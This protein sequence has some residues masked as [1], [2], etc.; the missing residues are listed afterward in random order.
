[1][2]PT[3]PFANLQFE[4]ALKNYLNKRSRMKYKIVKRE[5]GDTDL[6]RQSRSWTYERIEREL[7]IKFSRKI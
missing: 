7:G 2:R 5:T 3:R 4:N 1:M 6:A